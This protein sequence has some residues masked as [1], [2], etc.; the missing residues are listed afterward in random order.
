VYVRTEPVAGSHT[1]RRS[2]P[3]DVIPL[4][5]HIGAEV[6]GVD[7]ATDLDGDAIAAIRAALLQWKVVFFRDQHLDRDAHVAFGARFGE[8]TPAHPTLPAPFPERPEI[9]VVKADPH[10][11]DPG[12]S[13]L[14][15]RW[16]SDVTYVEAP[17]LGSILR[18]VQVPPFGADTE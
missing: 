14:E 2:V 13:I 1:N 7:L 12:D 16:H 5:Q 17:P 3:I 4:A 11:H 15:H 8:V 6:R 18:A 9:L 10:S